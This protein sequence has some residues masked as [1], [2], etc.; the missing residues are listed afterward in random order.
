MND[1]PGNSDQSAHH[2][3]QE[4]PKVAQLW[5]LLTVKDVAEHFTVSVGQNGETAKGLRSEQ[6]ASRASE[7]GL[8]TLREE[9]RRSAFSVI[10]AQFTSIIVLLLLV[11][12]WVAFVLGDLVEGTAILFV[13]VVNSAIGF[14]M[15]WRA[16][17]ALEALKKQVVPTA[18]VIRDGKEQRIA[19]VDLVPG[20]LVILSAG[21]RIAADGR[22][23]EAVRL[24][25][26][27]AALTGESLPVAKVVE[28]LT[29]SQVA[30]ADRINMVFKGTAV[31][32]GRG[33]MIVTS[34]G[35][36]TELGKIGKL[37]GEIVQ[38]K[39]PLERKLRH[40]GNMMVVVVL[41]LCTPLL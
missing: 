3:T 20:D 21:D 29:E 11:A 39:T 27:E 34:T 38:E 26:I 25:T 18:V 12:S 9:P 19:S 40:L 41:G 8:N 5:H 23:I 22:V 2:R 6:V 1:I 15:E 37:L 31:A 30:V 32:D 10:A 28:A 4:S 14:F 7:F 36:S 17:R 35:S 33:K 13:I 24:H 16:E